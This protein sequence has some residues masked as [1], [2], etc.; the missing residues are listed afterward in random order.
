MVQPVPD[1]VA[2]R[3]A[4]LTASE[5][6]CLR[7]RLWP[8]TAKEMALDLG[9]SP[10]AV[11][12]RLKMARA[13][14]G[15]SSS[16]AAARLLG[17]HEPDQVLVPHS[18]DLPADVP[19]SLAPSLGGRW[20]AFAQ[21]LRRPVAGVS[22][23]LLTILAAGLF[24]A[25]P[26]APDEPA[27][28]RPTSEAELAAM[29]ATRRTTPAETLQWLDYVFPDLDT[30]ASGFVDRNEA[31][32]VVDRS[33]KDGDGKVSLEE[34]RSVNLPIYLKYGIPADWK[35]ETQR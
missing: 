5:K 18:T 2:A 8:Q 16:L 33:D 23:M 14:L 21:T 13:K 22:I 32:R 17:A 27:I 26:T 19:I 6:E 25:Q 35:P 29:A 9:I 12:K 28:R 31:F 20:P 3:L 30:D 24:I 7:R 1:D 10:F 15:V 4:R 11:E 34:W